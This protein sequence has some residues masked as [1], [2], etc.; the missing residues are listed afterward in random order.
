MFHNRKQLIRNDSLHWDRW[1][2]SALHRLPLSY[3]SAD[4]GYQLLLSAIQLLRQCWHQLLINK[5]RG[6]RQTSTSTRRVIRS[7]NSAISAAVFSVALVA[8]GDRG[9]DGRCPSCR[10][11]HWH[12]PPPPPPPT[13]A[14]ATANRRCLDRRCRCLDRRCRCRCLDRRCRCLDRRCRR[15]LI[16]AHRTPF[17]H[18]RHCHPPLP[19]A[20]PRF[21]LSFSLRHPSMPVCVCVCVLRL[22]HGLFQR[23]EKQGGGEG[24]TRGKNS[25][26]TQ[27]FAPILPR[28]L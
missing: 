4:F 12:Q 26:S 20:T 19:P 5:P 23:A 28:L 11:R 27:Q 21:C 2:F 1:R 15:V 17:C 3:L 22:L 18:S 24:E 6:P 8:A 16:V 13:A 14:T 9:F 7:A 25:D 10:R